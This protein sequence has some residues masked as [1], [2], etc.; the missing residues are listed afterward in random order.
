MIT[1]ALCARLAAQAPVAGLSRRTTQP[2]TGSA[3]DVR[4]LKR[5]DRASGALELDSQFHRTQ[6]DGVETHE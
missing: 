4:M 3:P 5:C 6:S 1:A 2:Q